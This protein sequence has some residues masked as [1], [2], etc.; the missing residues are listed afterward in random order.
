LGLTYLDDFRDQK[1]KM[2]DDKKVKLDLGKIKSND[3]MIMFFVKT[4]DL[5]AQPPREGE[6]DRAMFRVL[7]EETNQTIDYRQ[8]KKIELPEGFEEDVAVEVEEGEEAPP[9]KAATYFAGRLFKEG[10]EWLYES[11]GHVFTS[12]QYPS[13]GTKLAGLYKETKQDYGS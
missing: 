2:N 6:F 11:Y 9:R 5:S 10:E 7:N 4:F 1:L 13:I 8:V 12:D 3:V